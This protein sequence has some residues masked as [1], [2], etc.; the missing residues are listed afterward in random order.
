MQ[1][2]VA[3]TVTKL[4]RAFFWNMISILV[5]FWIYCIKC[6]GTW[7]LSW[8]KTNTVEIDIVNYSRFFGA[9]RKAPFPQRCGWRTW[10]DQ[11]W[12]DE[13]NHCQ[14]QQ[15]DPTQ[16]CRSSA[17]YWLRV[18]RLP[19]SPWRPCWPCNPGEAW[20]DFWPAGLDQSLLFHSN[21]F[22]SRATLPP[23]STYPS[24]LASFP[25]SRWWL[26]ILLSHTTC[27]YWWL[28]R[29]DTT[30]DIY[31]QFDRKGLD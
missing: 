30:V 11:A 29:Q 8:V 3:N 23:S 6:K 18:G 17:P 12:G 20:S 19:N 15:G 31:K 13:D 22:F 2:M 14:V 28:Q 7:T 24:L 16:V 1:L 9:G 25:S 27:R 10:P 21:T 5:W 26:T 4:V